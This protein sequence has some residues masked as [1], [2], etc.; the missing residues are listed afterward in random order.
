[1]KTDRSIGKPVLIVAILA[2]ALVFTLVWLKSRPHESAPEVPVAEEPVPAPPAEPA[3]QAAAPVT[4]AVP[5]SPVNTNV[6]PPV[7]PIPLKPVLTEAENGSW[8]RDKDYL[9]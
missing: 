4:A 7:V 5:P 3:P 6:L 1:M 2:I 8:L 9:L